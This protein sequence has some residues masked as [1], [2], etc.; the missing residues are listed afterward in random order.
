MVNFKCRVCVG[1]TAPF[2]AVWVFR[3]VRPVAT[4]RVRVESDPEQTRQFGPIAN[5]TVDAT[6]KDVWAL[7]SSL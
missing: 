6:I 7:V 5:T 3:V 4:V 1:K 2:P